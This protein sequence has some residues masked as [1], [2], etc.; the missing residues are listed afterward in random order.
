MEGQ[1]YAGNGKLLGWMTRTKHDAC[2]HLGSRG[3]K[4]CPRRR[5][6]K[7]WRAKGTPHLT[8]YDLQTISKTKRHRSRHKK[9]RR[10]NGNKR[11]RILSMFSKWKHNSTN[12]TKRNRLPTTRQY[13]PYNQTTPQTT[14]LCHTNDIHR[15]PCRQNFT[16]KYTNT[17][18]LKT[19][20][21]LTQTKPSQ[22]RRKNQT[23]ST[24]TTNRHTFR[25]KSNQPRQTKNLPTRR[26]P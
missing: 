13:L 1:T 10:P 18:I 7:E 14:Q 6:H 12:T 22:D 11:E 15:Q 17:T 25:P 26:H 20:L 8:K 9:C 2:L 19:R 4:V 21:H 24:R 5:R 16:T 23:P 3:E